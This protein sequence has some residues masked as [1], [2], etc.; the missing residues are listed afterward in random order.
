MP[1]QQGN[2]EKKE[3]HYP[4]SFKSANDSIFLLQMVSEKIFKFDLIMGKETQKK[5]NQRKTL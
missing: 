1:K 3:F 4:P 2:M 5:I